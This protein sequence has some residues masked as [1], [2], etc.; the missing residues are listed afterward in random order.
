[1]TGGGFGGSAIALLP[2]EKV[3]DAIDTA[4]RLAAD[5]APAP[6]GWVR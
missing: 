1:M 6:E 5:R 2:A 4:R 3:D